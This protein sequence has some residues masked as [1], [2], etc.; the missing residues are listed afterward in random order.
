MFHFARKESLKSKESHFKGILGIC[1]R[2]QKV[3]PKVLYQHC[4]YHLSQTIANS[5]FDSISPGKNAR[6]KIR[7]I[8]NKVY[9]KKKKIKSTFRDRYIAKNILQS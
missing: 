5:P 7:L 6:S 8:K 9:F 2:M 4:G 3:F 1:L